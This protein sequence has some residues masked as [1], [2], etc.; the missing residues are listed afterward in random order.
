MLFTNA[1]LDEIRCQLRTLNVRIE[2]TNSLLAGIVQKLNAVDA[3]ITRCYNLIKG[4][5][6]ADYQ[7]IK[8]NIFLQGERMDKIV[9]KVTLA[10]P[11]AADVVGRFVQVVVAGE[12][13][14]N[15][16]IP[17]DKR[18]LGPFSGPQDSE[19][20]VTLVDIDDAG[21]HS[22]AAT[23]TMVLSDIFAPGQPAA[24]VIN[25]VAEVHEPVEQ[26][27]QEVTPAPETSEQVEQLQEETESSSS[28]EVPEGG[29]D[30]SAN[31]G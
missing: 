26:P 2:E 9:F 16:R 5:K 29:A 25:L 1:K 8:P 30:E 24:P 12:Q 20:T 21:N 3:S 19:V 15:E 10:P 6:F 22:T 11:E 28:E 7:P 23:A 13:V 17:V 31:A 18:E 4:W 14:F 27:T